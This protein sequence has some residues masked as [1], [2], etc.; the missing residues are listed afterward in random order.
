MSDNLSYLSGRKGLSD[1]LFD[2]YVKEADATDGTVDK[3]KLTE[4]AKEFL[5]GSANTYGATSFYDF[6][7]EEKPL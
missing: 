6:L 4:L 7:K 1:N 2:N 3:A 5:V